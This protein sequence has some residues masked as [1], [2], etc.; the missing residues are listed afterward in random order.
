[1][2]SLY[3]LS[4]LLIATLSVL[5]YHASAMDFGTKSSDVEGPPLIKLSPATVEKYMRDVTTALKGLE[6]FLLD[7]IESNK[8]ML[9]QDLDLSHATAVINMA[10]KIHKVCCGDEEFP[11]Y[12][13][14]TPDPGPTSL[15][16]SQEHD[17]QDMNISG[18]VYVEQDQ[19]SE[20]LN[21]AGSDLSASS[22][23]STVIE[24]MGLLHY[25]T[26][27]LDDMLVNYCHKDRIIQLGNGFCFICS[28]SGMDKPPLPILIPRFE[29]FPQKDNNGVTW[30]HPE[31]NIFHIAVHENKIEFL[32]SIDMRFELIN[33]SFFSDFDSSWASDPDLACDCPFSVYRFVLYDQDGK[34]PLIVTGSISGEGHHPQWL[35]RC[36]E[37]PEYIFALW[38]ALPEDVKFYSDASLSA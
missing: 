26:T 33:R 30:V 5:Q 12:D 38:N 35:I 7:L 2:N 22:L 9:S 14:L 23:P 15:E 8:D 24:V 1:M 32:H 13:F 36:S 4:L 37:S 28:S 10:K 18:E 11:V 19:I 16:I 31:T 25:M 20:S 6:S 17:S 27:S 3:Y 34:D 29:I 21:D